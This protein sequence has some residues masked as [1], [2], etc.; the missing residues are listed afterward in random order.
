MGLAKRIHGL[1][2]PF[3]RSNSSNH[4]HRPSVREPGNMHTSGVLAPD[5]PYTH[6]GAMAFRRE[7]PQRAYTHL[8]TH[9]VI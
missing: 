3:L 7:T 1:S 4:R 8:Q 5:G 6:I 2:R 9:M